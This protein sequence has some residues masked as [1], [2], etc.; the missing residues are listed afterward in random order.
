[1]PKTEEVTRLHHK[2]VASYHRHVI[3]KPRKNGSPAELVVTKVDGRIWETALKLAK[4]DSTRI[5][6]RS[7]TEVVVVNRSK[8]R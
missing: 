3:K 2:T 7:P 8:K 6:V 5:V 4:G 1:M